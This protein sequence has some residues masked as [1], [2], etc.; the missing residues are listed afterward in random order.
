MAANPTWITKG[1]ELVY[2]CQAAREVGEGIREGQGRHDHGQRAGRIAGQRVGD[3]EDRQDR[4][5]TYT[6]STV[7][8]NGS[9]SITVPYPT[10]ADERYRIQLGRH[11]DHEVHHYLRQHDED[12][13]TCPESA[14]MNGL[15]TVRKQVSPR[16]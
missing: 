2:V 4:T 16:I 3:A 5:F 14:V 8:Q 9:Y 6:N 1:V 7:A 13:W 15:I 12:A 11:A 10:E